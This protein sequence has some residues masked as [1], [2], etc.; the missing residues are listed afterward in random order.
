MRILSNGQGSHADSRLKKPGKKTRL[1]SPKYF[2][3]TCRSLSS[4]L[5]CGDVLVDDA[6]DRLA[7]DGS[8]DPL[9]LLTILKKY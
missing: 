8:Y 5:L 9:L 1:F 7:G 4:R 6:G 2:I 3:K